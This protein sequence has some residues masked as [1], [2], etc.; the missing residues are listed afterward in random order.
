M[1]FINLP[2][3]V[4]TLLCMTT[5]GFA[6]NYQWANSIGGAQAG[7]FAAGSAVA[8]D[9]ASWIAGS[10][11]GPNVNFDP[12][13]SN[14]NAIISGAGGQNGF[15]VRYLPNGQFDTVYHFISP[16]VVEVFEVNATSTPAVYTTGEFRS[17]SFIGG[18]VFNGPTSQSDVFVARI[19]A[20]GDFDWVYQLNTEASNPIGSSTA[21]DQDNLW[22][23]GEFKGVLNLH[24]T[25]PDF[26]V[27]TGFSNGF[28]AG[29]S[30][31]GQLLTGFAIN[32]LGSVTVD[33]ICMGSNQDFW[34]T[35]SF[36]DTT[37]F[38]PDTADSAIR[39]SFS[40]G[41]RNAY[42]A[43]Y[44]TQGDFIEVITLG[45]PIGGPAVAMVHD[46]CIDPFGNPI[47]AG[48]IGGSVD[49]SPD[50][51]TTALTSNGINDIFMAKYT[52]S[53]DLLWAN[54][55][56]AGESDVV[57]DM[58]MDDNFRIYITGEF[59]E[60]VDMDPSSNT[61]IIGL[62]NDSL[63]PY[64]A[65]YSINGDHIWSH[66]F[67]E[68]TPGPLPQG[69]SG[70]VGRTVAT[71]GSNT[72][73]FGGLFD[74][75]TDFDPS[76]GFGFLAPPGIVGA[77]MANYSVFDSFAVNDTIDSIE[78]CEGNNVTLMNTVSGV[79]TFTYQWQEDQGSGFGDLSNGGVYSGVNTT[80]LDIQPASPSMNGYRYRLV[81]SDNTSGWAVGNSIT[82]VVETLPVAQ[83]LNND[84][85]VCQGDS[86]QFTVTATGS[87]LSYQWQ[88]DI[89]GG[90]T[91]IDVSSF[92]S[93][94]NP[95]TPQLTIFPMDASFD[96][97][98]F[99]CRVNTALC[100]S[101]SN[102]N[103][104]NLLTAPVPDFS[105]TQDSTGSV[106]FQNQST[107]AQAYVWDFG[108]GIGTDTAANPSH[109]YFIT[110]NTQFS[111]TLTASNACDTVDT[112]IDIMV[113]LVGIDDLSAE[114]LALEVYPNPGQ[115]LLFIEWNTNRTTESTLE[116][117]DMSGRV[118]M[119]RE[120]G[121]AIAMPYT[122]NIS[123]IPPGFY[124][125]KVNTGEAIQIRKVQKM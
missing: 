58:A 83:T 81:V 41:F 73:L 89:G 55:F 102:D 26:V 20:A 57:E 69:L 74:Q 71:G 16:S 5:S 48:H 96:G 67:L 9:G 2:I 18:Q 87:N 37:D 6:Q 33:G 86:A 75:D 29:Y 39:Y 51:T 125:L 124:L 113:V 30:P 122:L 94:F 103:Q 79:G 117:Q 52:P 110:Q 90:F 108:D 54:S 85:N 65:C 64:L 34:V 91:D 115:D 98:K 13:N 1:K 116:L 3:W 99:R 84:T 105:F 68:F 119:R 92:P 49:F 93:F 114:L 14:P 50:S 10:F 25:Q 21:D 47:I 8:N 12:T 82:L 88:V 31:S 4:A 32:S 40:S 80:T 100:E 77:F 28:V 121:K 24:P 42:L 62:V 112:T 78:V 36:T 66:G 107:S 76:A 56:G 123:E 104:L 106:L 95:G 43:H 61:A 27:N 7:A 120:P 44:T 38:D 111:V 109:F 60:A 72:L 63:N 59:S 35:G 45:D 70:S 118:V 97:Y 46:I 19:D 17:T 15:L 22:V 11:G 53:G 101:F 23:C